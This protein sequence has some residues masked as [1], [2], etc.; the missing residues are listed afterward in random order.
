MSEVQPEHAKLAGKQAGVIMKLLNGKIVDVVGASSS[1][2]HSI[3]VAEIMADADKTVG[4]EYIPKAVKVYD[5][6]P[7]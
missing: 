5:L 4:V 3:K 1:E 7:I 6:N 2:I